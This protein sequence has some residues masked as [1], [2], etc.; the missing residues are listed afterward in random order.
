MIRD[1]H[2]MSGCLC[3]NMRRASRVMT[4][5]FTASLPGEALLPTQTPILTALEEHPG[6]GMAELS[7]WIGMDRTTLLRNLGPLEREGLVAAEGKGKGS[8]VALFL[9]PKGRKA[10]RDLLPRWRRTQEKALK[11]LGEKR[12]QEIL[13]DLDRV[14]VALGS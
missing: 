12:W 11:V 1:L 14:A 5:F 8:R 13:S 3:Y 2:Q 10:L 7:E 6:A 9:T 4:Q